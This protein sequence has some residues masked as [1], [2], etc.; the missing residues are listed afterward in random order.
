MKKS[1]AVLPKKKRGRPAT[2]RDPLLNFRCPPEITDGLD[3]W[4]AGQQDPKPTRSDAARQAIREWLTGLGLV[5]PDNTSPDLE[6]RKT[7][8][9]AVRAKAEAVVDKALQNVQAAPEEKDRRKRKLTQ[10]GKS[11]KDR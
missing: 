1:I 6:A 9:S 8:R 2:G 4:I 11:L 10:I 3:Q 7:Q 5:K